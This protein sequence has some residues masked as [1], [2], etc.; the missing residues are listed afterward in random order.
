MGRQMNRWIFA[1]V[2]L[3]AAVLRIGLNNVS[4]YSPADETVYVSYTKTLTERGFVQ[5]Y[6]E[7]VR[8]FVEQPRRWKY[9]SPIR[10]G[11]FAATTFVAEAYGSADP[12]A[13]D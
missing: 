9:P 1:V 8:A 4:A 6:P 11:Y 3:A 13:L 10:W 12:R 5:G 2:L 7:I